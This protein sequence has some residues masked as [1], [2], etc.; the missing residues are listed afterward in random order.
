VKHCIEKG[1]FYHYK[2]DPKGRIENYAYEVL[3]VAKD[4]ENG[5][6]N[7][8]YRPIYKCDY[9]EGADF[10]SRPIENFLDIIKKS[11]TNDGQVLKR[12]TKIS[13]VYVTSELKKI[14]SV[15]EVL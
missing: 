6:Q 1:F 10:F 4:S 9:L 8:I 13:D 3:G 2:H 7:V 12:F 15:G 5:A 11:E 14:L